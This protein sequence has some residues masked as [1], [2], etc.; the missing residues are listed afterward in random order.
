LPGAKPAGGALDALIVGI[1]SRR[2][3]SSSKLQEAENLIVID[4]EVLGRSDR[5]ERTVFCNRI[6]DVV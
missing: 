6:P 5:G 2:W 1:I 3:T 4:Y